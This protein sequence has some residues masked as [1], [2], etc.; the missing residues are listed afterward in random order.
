MLLSFIFLLIYYN[1][2]MPTQHF[3]V[4][5]YTSGGI[6]THDNFSSMTTVAFIGKRKEK[7]DRIVNLTFLSAFYYPFVILLSECK[8][9]GHLLQALCAFIQLLADGSILLCTC[10]IVFY[11]AGYFL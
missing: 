8:G 4:K 1:T 6:R 2:I 9:I 10:R 5:G 11:N 7:T 3:P